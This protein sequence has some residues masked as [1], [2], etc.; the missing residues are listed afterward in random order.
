MT[1]ARKDAV[2]TL[3]MI[4]AAADQTFA[5]PPA[6]RTSARVRVR[7]RVMGLEFGVRVRV[8]ARIRGWG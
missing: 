4:S 8:V 3:A 1:A 2:S 7:F 6:P 5:P